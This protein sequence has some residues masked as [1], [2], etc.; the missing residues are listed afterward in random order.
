[1]P[2]QHVVFAQRLKLQSFLSNC[3][4]MHFEKKFSSI[5]S[6]YD[7]YYWKF[8]FEMKCTLYLENSVLELN[9]DAMTDIIWKSNRV[10]M[11]ECCCLNTDIA[12]NA[13][14]QHAMN[15]IYHCM[16]SNETYSFYNWPEFSIF[17]HL[18]RRIIPNAS[19]F[20]IVLE[21]RIRTT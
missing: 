11:T 7:V 21:H 9:C 19:L 14:A 17:Q 6:L 16:H 4:R 13:D 2:K 12:M 10:K 3:K 20:L 1:M 5:D 15:I 18:I 8:D